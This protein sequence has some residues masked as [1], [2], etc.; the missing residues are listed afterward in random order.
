M[1]FA[2]FDPDARAEFLDAV[3]YYEECQEGLGS[4]FLTA[5]ETAVKNISDTPF[6]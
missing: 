5:I 4:R 3:R 2:I 6:L 1:T